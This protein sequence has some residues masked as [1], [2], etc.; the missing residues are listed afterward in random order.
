MKIF[1]M[2]IYE[3]IAP[4]AE[5]LNVPNTYAERA[6]FFWGER[7]H[8]IGETFWFINIIFLCKLFVS[9]AKGI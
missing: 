5:I 9:P 8:D 3:Q 4:Q 6:A 7:K 1:A 2:N